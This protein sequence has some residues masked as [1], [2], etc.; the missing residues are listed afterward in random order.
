MKKVL[1]VIDYKIAPLAGLL[2]GQLMP[3]EIFR[4]SSLV[5]SIVV[6][7]VVKTVGKYKATG[8]RS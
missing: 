4:T 8:T 2:K 3:R 5:S 7:I 6:R 1:F